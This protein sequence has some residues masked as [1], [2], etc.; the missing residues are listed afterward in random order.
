MGQPTMKNVNQTRNEI[1]SEYTKAKTTHPSFSQ[2]YRFGFT[3]T[4]PKKEKIRSLHNAVEGV[5]EEN[6]LAE[7][8]EFAYPA[9]PDMYDETIVGNMLDATRR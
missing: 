1:A 8:W 7:A 3:S 5:E 4:I 9:R 6:E 2:G